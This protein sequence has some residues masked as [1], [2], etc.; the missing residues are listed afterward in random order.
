M[1]ES[2]YQAALIKKIEHRLPGCLITMNDANH[3]QGLPDLTIFYKERWAWLEVKA[4]EK[5]R[6]R[7]NQRHYIETCTSFSA[8][9]FPENEEA[10][11][12]ELEDF[13]GVSNAAI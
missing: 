6:E 8:F 5:S 12:M 11:L 7:P 4:S 3:R 10:V 13:M 9:I 1:L 2:K